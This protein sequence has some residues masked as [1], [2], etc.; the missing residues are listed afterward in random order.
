MRQA[1]TLIGFILDVVSVLLYMMTGL[2]HS[3]PASGSLAL[4]PLCLIAFLLIK[5]D[6][7]LIVPNQLLL[8]IVLFSCTVH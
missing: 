4:L 7:A 3:L 2:G 5:F 6:Q 8:G 1:C